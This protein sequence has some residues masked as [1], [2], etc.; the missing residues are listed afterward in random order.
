M[1]RISDRVAS[2]SRGGGRMTEES[3]IRDVVEQIRCVRARDGI[4]KELSDHI[5]DQTAAYEEKGVTHEEAVRRA[6]QEM[7][8]PVE[9]G[10]ELDRIHRPQTDYK[11]I[12]MAFLFHIAGFFIIY[13]V[14]YLSQHPEYIGRQCVTLLLSFCVMAGMYFLDY[15]FIARYAYGT[16]MFVTIVILGSLILSVGEGRIPGIM[17]SYL[18]V[19]VFAGIL[20]RQRNGG[21]RA[22]MWAMG[23]QIV[24]ACFTFCFSGMLHTANI[25]M[26]C[27][28]L[29]FLA[30][31]KG[32]FSVNKKRAA[33]IM[34]G[35]LVLLPVA[36]MSVMV[37]TGF[38]SIYGFQA[39]RLL[40]WLNP[41]QDAQ[42]AGY[43]YLLLRQ[44]WRAVR[45]I[46]AADNSLLLSDN[47]VGPTDPLILL[48]LICNYGVLAGL[49]LIA[50]FAA[51]SI[52]AFQIVKRQKNQIGFML[53]AACFMVILLN[54]LEGVLSNTGYFLVSNMQFPFVSCN[55]YTGITYAVLIG[56]L[57]SIYRNERIITD[58]T[59]KRP[60][61]K[62]MVKFEKR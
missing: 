10:V 55:V 49:V 62:L 60:T 46:G 59:V 45:L 36:L 61:W 21:Y 26:V 37:M 48:Q 54:C 42:G 52:R 25:Y 2:R 4:A 50:A 5:E 40:A 47:S 8:D 7:G 22:L 6:V 11:L 19:P 24:T 58:K 16:F 29:I 3:Y 43:I 9:V 32:W 12:G 39:Q 34:T 18:Y 35:V 41:K 15:S 1:E 56:L 53:S 57:L 31:A 13:Q 27:T 28:F 33:A 51:L 23:M 14:G 20:Y 30:A 38:F 17:L 44:E